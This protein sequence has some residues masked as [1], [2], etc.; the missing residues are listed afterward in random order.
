MTKATL[1]CSR[2]GKEFA[3]A[4]A[5]GLPDLQGSPKQVAWA[6][7]IR[8]KKLE[9]LNRYVR[10]SVLEV[11]N[12]DWPESQIA[13]YRKIMSGLIQDAEAVTSAKT[14][15]DWRG[16]TAEQIFIDLRRIRKLK[17]GNHDDMG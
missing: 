8:A 6:M 12:S 13:E 14:W 2:C 7:S 11:D 9:A 16:D 4:K 3:A 1:I 10:D 17:G 5:A 15:I